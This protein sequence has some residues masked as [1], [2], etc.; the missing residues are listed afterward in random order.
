MFQILNSRIANAGYF[1]T[2]EED[3]GTWKRVTLCSQRTSSGYSGTSFWVTRV[4][5]QWFL[6]V[7]SGLVYSVESQE[8][9]ADIAIS[10]F[11]QEHPTTRANLSPEFIERYHL[12]DASDKFDNSI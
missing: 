5:N 11:M 1:V 2:P 7:W 9:I 10:W 8:V 12:Q 6:G 4:Q 3:M